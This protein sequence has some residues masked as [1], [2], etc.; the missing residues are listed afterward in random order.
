M[1]AFWRIQ[2]GLRQDDVAQ[3]LGVSRETI[4]NWET[5]RRVPRRPLLGRYIALVHRLR[6]EV[7]GREGAA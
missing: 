1:C 4:A 5:G 7:M 6:Q 2:A 3:E